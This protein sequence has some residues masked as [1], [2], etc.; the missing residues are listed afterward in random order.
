MGRLKG[1]KNEERSGLQA[2]GVGYISRFQ[3]Q[4][5]QGAE[6]TD[7]QRVPDIYGIGPDVGYKFVTRSPSI[8]GH[9]LG[10]FGGVIF[11]K[12]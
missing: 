3:I 10:H 11:A 5:G 12:H 4:E 1:K 9:R 7:R 8:Q 2:V 6:H